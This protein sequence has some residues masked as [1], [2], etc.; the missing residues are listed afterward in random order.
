MVGDVAHEVI[1][2][3]IGFEIFVIALAIVRLAC[4]AVALR[5]V[6]KS[7]YFD[8]QVF[9][10]SSSVARRVARS[11]LDDFGR[12]LNDTQERG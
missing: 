10:L 8:A 2:E 7:R 4:R 5:V 11:Y 3:L 1:A 6:G 12:C 9:P